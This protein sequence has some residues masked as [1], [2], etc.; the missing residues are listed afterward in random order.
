[1]NK[2]SALCIFAILLCG[3]F[4]SPA[5]AADTVKPTVS[6]TSPK[7][8]ARVTS[9]DLVVTGTARDN[10]AL[11]GV[12][13][14]LNGG[15]WIEPGTANGWTNWSV[16]LALAPGANKV[17]AYATDQAGNR[18][19]TNELAVTFVVNSTLS[20]QIDGPG[21][22]TAVPGGLRAAALNLIFLG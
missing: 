7:A 3:A 15:E 20:L 14:S 22:V 5:I 6:I 4:Q 12:K 9:A 1:M 19:T 10:S 2:R 11:A 13:V 8:N 16:A 18:S 21:K 17:R